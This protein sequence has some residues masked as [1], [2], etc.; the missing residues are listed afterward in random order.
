MT[1]HEDIHIDF[2]QRQ[3]YVTYPGLI[4]KPIIAGLREFLESNV[5]DALTKVSGELGGLDKDIPSSVRR[6]D[7]EGRLGD[8][9]KTAKSILSGHFPLEVRLSRNF[10]EVPKC[11]AFR[12][13]LGAMISTDRVFMHMPPAAR[14]VLPGNL[15][16]GVP[17]H[18]DVA[19]GSHMS[20]FITVWVPLV[21]IDEHCGGVAVFEAS[22]VASLDVPQHDGEFWLR[23]L[24]TNGFRR[25]E[26]RLNAGDALVL[27]KYVIH[28]SVGN[29]SDRTRLSVDFRFFGEGQSSSKH[30]LDLQSWEVVSPDAS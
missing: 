24:S 10:W 3:G 30:F 2:F 18:Q 21:D 11:M 20:D 7:D 28:E 6:L 22:H 5:D 16:A 4:P 19:Y 25:V 23:P 14:F 12:Q 13:M 9:S 27:H 8:L 26:C 1:E 29:R 15:H 17:A